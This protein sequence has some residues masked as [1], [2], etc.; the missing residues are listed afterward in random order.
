MI[1]MQLYDQSAR[2]PDRHAAHAP[3]G[4]N[5]QLSHAHL[6]DASGQG[7][8]R[9]CNAVASRR[10]LIRLPWLRKLAQ[11]DGCGTSGST[12]RLCYAVD[13]E[14]SNAEAGA[15][16]GIWRLLPVLLIVWLAGGG[17]LGQESLSI[18]RAARPLSGKVDFNVLTPDR[19]RLPGA[20]GAGRLQGAVGARAAAARYAQPRARRPWSPI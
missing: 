11:A 8:F 2:E 14:P 19:E 17:A 6:K 15:L 9:Q 4:G 13:R 16:G 1:A 12:E 10:P 5:C 20:A 18:P 3:D 7:R